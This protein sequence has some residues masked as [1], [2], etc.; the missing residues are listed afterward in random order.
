ME[1][2]GQSHIFGGQEE[3]EGKCVE[4]DAGGAATRLY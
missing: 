1:I 2:S 3:D 4:G